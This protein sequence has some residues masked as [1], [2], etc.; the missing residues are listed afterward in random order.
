LS[1]FVLLKI[2]QGLCFNHRYLVG[3]GGEGVDMQFASSCLEVNV[4]ERLESGD[5]EVWEFDKHASI[6]CEPLEVDMALSIH[7][8]AH[9]LDLKIGHITYASAQSAFMGAWASE[10]ES[11]NQAL[12]RQQL[13]WCAYNLTEADAAGKDAGHM[14]AAGNPDSSF[15]FLGFWFSLGVDLKELRMQRSL[16]KTECQFL[17]GYI[18]LRRFHNLKTYKQKCQPTAFTLLYKNHPVQFKG[19]ISIDKAESGAYRTIISQATQPKR[20]MGVKFF[21]KS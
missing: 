14:G 1:A 15:V 10:L 12:M 9:F 13:V 6:S 2:E 16:K 4:A 7:I 20:L 18:D 11:F 19:N 21:E 3:I 5:F 17:N 8:C